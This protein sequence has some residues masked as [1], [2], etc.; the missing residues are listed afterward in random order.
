M[1]CYSD[2]GEEQDP[3]CGGA[4]DSLDFSVNGWKEDQDQEKSGDLIKILLR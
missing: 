4:E 2:V 3:G 1:V